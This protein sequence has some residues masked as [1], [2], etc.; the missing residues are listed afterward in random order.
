MHELPF[1]THGGIPLDVMI[2]QQYDEALERVSHFAA[3]RIV[4]EPNRTNQYEHMERVSLLVHDLHGLVAALGRVAQRPLYA[5]EPSDP[6]ASRIIG[7]EQWMEMVSI[8]AVSQN[9]GRHDTLKKTKIIRLCA[10]RRE[11]MLQAVVYTRDTYTIHR[12]AVRQVHDTI[13]FVIHA[14]LA[15]RPHEESQR[16]G[17]WDSVAGV[18][19]PF[20]YPQ[21]LHDDARYIASWQEVASQVIRTTDM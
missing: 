9:G 17:L 11:G 1:I 8:A 6:D 5:L 14:P 16:F 7:R 15:E 4:V 12:P 18:I 20:S 10:G 19:H 2:G 3:S 21:N 13:S